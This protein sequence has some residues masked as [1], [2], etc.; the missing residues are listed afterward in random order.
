MH[1][2]EIFEFDESQD[3]M[4]ILHL[5]NNDYTFSSKNNIPFP[6]VMEGLIVETQQITG[7]PVS[8]LCEIDDLKQLLSLELLNMLDQNIIVKR[9]KYCGSYFIA[10]NLKNEYCDGYAPNEKKPCSE[11]GS[12][13]A[14]QNKQKKDEIYTVHQQAYK[15]HFARINKGKMT[16][17]AFNTWTLEAKQKMAD[18]REERLSME[19]YIAWL[20]V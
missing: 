15:T 18:I 7:S 17:A 4:D 14:Y 13:R 19:E 9:C 11:I 10:A 3:R 1:M 2:T 6:K 8:E 20:K 16:Q 12:A 5:H